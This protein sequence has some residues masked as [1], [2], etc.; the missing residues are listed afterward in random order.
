MREAQQK[1]CEVLACL[2]ALNS[3]CTNA[4]KSFL[5]SLT[6]PV[7]YFR[8]RAITANVCK[9]DL[10]HLPP[11]LH[12]LVFTKRCIIVLNK[13]YDEIAIANEAPAVYVVSGAFFVRNIS[14]VG[15]EKYIVAML[16]E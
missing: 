14:V 13:R 10:E 11:R 7:R 16:N 2:F 5:E 4:S 15:R 1:S 8:S 12:L 6:G 9:V 3:Y